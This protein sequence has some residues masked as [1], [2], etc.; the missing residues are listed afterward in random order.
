MPKIYIYI[1][2]SHQDSEESGLGL[3]AQV[4]SCLRYADY[5]RCKPTY[6]DLVLHET[7]FVDVSTSAFR[8]ESRGFLTRKAGRRLNMRL[9]PGDHVVFARLDRAFRWVPEFYKMYE[10]WQAK[11][12]T[13]HFVDMQVDL[14]TAHGRM[15]A[16]IMAVVAEWYSSYISERTKEGLLA[17]RVRGEAV[18]AR[19]NYGERGVRRP[20]GTLI[21]VPDS[22]AMAVLRYVRILRD[23]HELSY[24]RIGMRIEKIVAAREERPIRKNGFGLKWHPRKVRDMWLAAYEVWPHR[25]D[26]PEKREKRRRKR[27]QP[28][29]PE[30]LVS[31]VLPE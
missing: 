1:R 29:A 27:R 31:G 13:M 6:E 17:K 19:T 2:C 11:G 24:A 30:V 9:E 23:V 15:F 12:I 16:G 14:S 10:M 21:S 3:E 22:E 26:K 4:T 7:P 25:Y 8:K 18:K 5:I 28:S 20:D